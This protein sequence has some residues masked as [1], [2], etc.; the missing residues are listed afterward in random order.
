[1]G[2]PHRHQFRNIPAVARD[3]HFDHVEQVYKLVLGFERTDLRG[4][5]SCNPRQ[6]RLARW[7]RPFE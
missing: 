3:I 7:R 1:M 2:S 5:R 6:A 4:G